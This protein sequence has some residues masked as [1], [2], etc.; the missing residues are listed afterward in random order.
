[1]T[2][3]EAL[4]AH[5]VMTATCAIQPGRVGLLRGNSVDT[6]DAEE[7]GTKEQESLRRVLRM[8]DHASTVRQAKEACTCRGTRC[9][10]SPAIARS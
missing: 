4:H 2:T 10:T 8:S 6:A 3:E 5:A 9:S 7:Q 1:M